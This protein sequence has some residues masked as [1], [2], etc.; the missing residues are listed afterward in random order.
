MGKFVR[1]TLLQ[2]MEEYLALQL[3]L[4]GNAYRN[5]RITGEQFAD[6]QTNSYS[7]TITRR[8]PSY[9]I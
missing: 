1:T 9:E 7:N 4:R 2:G 6:L 5:R 3:Q 8:I